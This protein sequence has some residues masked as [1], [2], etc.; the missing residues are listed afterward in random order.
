MRWSLEGDDANLLNILPPD[1]DTEDTATLSFIWL[2]TNFPD[3]ENPMDKNGDNVYEVTI[4]VTDSTLVNRD[5]LDVTVKV[6]NST[7]DNRPGEVLLSNR[8]PEGASALT[9]TLDDK[10][11]PISNLSWQWYRSDDGSADNPEDCGAV[12]AVGAD[13]PHVFT[14]SSGLGT[15][16]DGVFTPTDASWEIIHGAMSET[17]TPKWDEDA[18][19]ND[20]QAA[21]AGKCLMATAHVHGLGRR[22][23]H[24]GG[25]PG[26]PHRG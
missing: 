7:E 17:Y 24:H 20:P 2:G 19:A 9:A 5:E 18:G 8:Q 3:F 10:D 23:P 13:T 12:S 4:V 11:K 6:I 14:P 15:V 16:T 25:R 21:D 26:H 1:K 22:G